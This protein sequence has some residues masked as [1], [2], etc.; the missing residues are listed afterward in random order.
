[1]RSKT[2][3]KAGALGTTCVTTPLAGEYTIV[4]IDTHRRGFDLPPVVVHLSR[5]AQGEVSVIGLRRR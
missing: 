4:R 5:T 2:D 1:V 3:A